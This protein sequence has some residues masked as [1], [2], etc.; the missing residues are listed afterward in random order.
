MNSGDGTGNRASKISVFL[1]N[2]TGNKVRIIKPTS[3]GASWNRKYLLI[4]RAR[5]ARFERATF[6]SGGQHSI[7]LS[8]GRIDLSKP[9]VEKLRR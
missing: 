3:N 6:G 5:P 4:S 1:D 7:Q 9:E 2:D 8:Y